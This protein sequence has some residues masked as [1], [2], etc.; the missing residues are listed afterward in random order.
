MLSLSGLRWRGDDARGVFGNDPGMEFGVR[1]LRLPRFLVELLMSRYIFL[2][3]SLLPT[4]TAAI[5]CRC[6]CSRIWR[7]G[8]MFRRYTVTLESVGTQLKMFVKAEDSPKRPALAGVASG[9]AGAG[10]A[11]IERPYAAVKLDDIEVVDSCVEEVGA[12]WGRDLDAGV[13]CA[14]SV[15]DGLGIESQRETRRRG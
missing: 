6:I 11:L 10:M 9:A 15:V 8:I 12:V 2:T 13:V 7:S 3:L 14:S 4:G 1:F 5:L